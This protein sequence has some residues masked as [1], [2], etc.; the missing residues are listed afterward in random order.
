MSLYY[1]R[2][3]QKDT[4]ASL[5]QRRKTQ[6]QRKD[7]EMKDLVDNYDVE[8][9][10]GVMKVDSHNRNHQFTMLEGVS[11]KESI[12]AA[13]N[14]RSLKTETSTYD[15]GGYYDM[16]SSYQSRKQIVPS[17][18]AASAIEHPKIENSHAATQLHHAISNANGEK[19]TATTMA[20]AAA[21]PTHIVSPPVP[22]RI[23]GNRTNASASTSNQ[24][25]HQE[26][27]DGRHHYGSCSPPLA[28]TAAHSHYNRIHGYHNY[29]QYNPYYGHHNYHNFYR[30]PQGSMPDS[31]TNGYTS[32][33]DVG[34]TRFTRGG[35][36]DSSHCTDH[37]RHHHHE[38][39][40]YHN[41]GYNHNP[42]SP[43]RYSNASSKPNDG[44]H[45]MS[46]TTASM[47]MDTS[48]L[49][50]HST[51][52]V[53]HASTTRSTLLSVSSSLY[54]SIGDPSLEVYKARL[55]PN[56]MHLLDTI[57]IQSEQYAATQ[58][59]GWRTDLYS[60]TR[61]DLA[62]C[63]IPGMSQ[64]IQPIVHTIHS[65]I[66]HLYGDRNNGHCNYGNIPAAS[67][68][69][70]MD[71]GDDEDSYED[72]YHHH[73]S[74]QRHRHHWGGSSNKHR[75]HRRSN[76]DGASHRYHS[77]N[78]SSKNDKKVTV[79]EM[80]RNQPHILKYSKASGHTG[81]KSSLG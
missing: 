48:V 40:V 65:A 64:Y 3:N 8:D 57:V 74:H 59:E 12:Q 42:S 22:Y 76:K 4:K 19:P 1:R 47:M 78:D 30:P 71:D 73:H 7:E 75:R 46:L 9:N 5:S 66:I 6:F 45:S 13:T 39:S 32:D 72:H 34:P 38:G 50:R 2:A 11:R 62:L 79:I 53:P 51:R 27:Y 41:A 49:N 67:S 61:Q 43:T 44:N 28:T 18:T 33:L 80:D 23:T 26:H 17:S 21:N 52:T 31:H 58:K 70:S 15:R 69:D 16:P 60:L 24:S 54:E 29:S 56:L 77:N 10:D 55:P 36:A 25:A 20:S 14:S 68:S 63:D 81:G 35:V 37:H